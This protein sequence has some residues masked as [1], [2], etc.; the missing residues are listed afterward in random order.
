V[1]EVT[2]MTAESLSELSRGLLIARKLALID[3]VFS[4]PAIFGILLVNNIM[5]NLRVCGLK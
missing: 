3:T 1:I 2:V 5:D 4:L